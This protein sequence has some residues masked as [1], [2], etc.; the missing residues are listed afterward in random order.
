MTNSATMDELRKIKDKCSQARLSRT[1]EEQK[2]H[3]AEVKKRAEAAIGRKIE[4]VNNSRAKEEV[5][6]V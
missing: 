5:S 6:L 2:K 1:P 4:T 3:S